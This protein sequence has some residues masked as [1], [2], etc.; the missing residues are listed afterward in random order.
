MKNFAIKSGLAVFCLLL[1]VEALSYTLN[2][3]DSNTTCKVYCDNKDL[4]GEMFWNGSKWSD[5]LR[6]HTDKG[7]LAKQIVKAQGSQCQ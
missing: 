5:G 2:C 4:A 7:I 1:Q 3:N 6:A